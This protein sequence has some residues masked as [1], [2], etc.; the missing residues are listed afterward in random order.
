MPMQAAHQGG[1][2]APLRPDLNRVETIETRLWKGS[3]RTDAVSQ[4]RLAVVDDS[5]GDR[6][7][8]GGCAHR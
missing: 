8:A 3:Q 1:Q 2:I 6:C 7:E 5:K 4:D